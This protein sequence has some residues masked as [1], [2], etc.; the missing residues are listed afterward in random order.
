[1]VGRD[2]ISSPGDINLREKTNTAANPACRPQGVLLLKPW[3][4]VMMLR[5]PRR[6]HA[7]PEWHRLAGDSR[8]TDAFWEVIQTTRDLADWFSK[9]KE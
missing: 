5:A 1:M 8:W 3:K 9:I 7:V 4:Q 2:Y 6:A